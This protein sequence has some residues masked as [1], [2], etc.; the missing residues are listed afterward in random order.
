M[1]VRTVHICEHCR[2]D[3][4]ELAEENTAIYTPMKTGQHATCSVCMEKG[5][6]AGLVYDQIMVMNRE[7]FDRA[8]KSH[9]Q[10]MKKAEEHKVIVF[11]PSKKR[12][13]PK[14]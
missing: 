13:M 5:K 3:Y 4:F 7:A 9:E 8:V 2:K 10:L 1:S 6:T 12:Q 11:D 14:K